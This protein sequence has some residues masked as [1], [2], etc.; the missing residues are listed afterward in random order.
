MTRLV[1][2]IVLTVM[3]HILKYSITLAI[4][5]DYTNL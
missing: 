4:Q 2:I 1:K 5:S 3:N